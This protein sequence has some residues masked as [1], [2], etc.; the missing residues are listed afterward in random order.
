M[1]QRDFYKEIHGARSL[2]EARFEVRRSKGAEQ[3]RVSTV[4]DELQV[5]CLM[6]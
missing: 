2:L 3:F 5:E 1:L 4:T 6:T